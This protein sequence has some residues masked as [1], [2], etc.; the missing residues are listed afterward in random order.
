M[1]DYANIECRDAVLSWA[2]TDLA[3][4]ADGQLLSRWDGKT[5]KTHLVT[6]ALVP[7]EAAMVPQWRYIRPA[8]AKWPKVDFIVGNSPFIGAKHLRDA[9]GD[10][11]A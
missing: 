7:D 9:L 3:Y 5:F 11:Y 6:G 10:G 8:Q 4:D 1:H 2:D